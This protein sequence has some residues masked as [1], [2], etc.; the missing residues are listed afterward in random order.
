MR[1]SWWRQ[2]GKLFHLDYFIVGYFQRSNIRNRR[3]I[4]MLYN[5]CVVFSSFFFFVQT[6]RLSLVCWC[7]RCRF[8]IASEFRAKSWK[9]IKYCLL[10]YPND[11]Q[12]FYYFFFFCYVRS[13]LWDLSTLCIVSTDE[14]F[15]FFF[16]LQFFLHICFLWIFIR[17]DSSSAFGI[18]IGVDVAI[19]IVYLSSFWSFSTF[20]IRLY[21]ALDTTIHTFT[22]YLKN[23][24]N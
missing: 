23:I 14:D 22:Y 18:E 8:S 13:V 21:A 7:C 4:V 19:T 16:Y 17:V 2:I 12:H 6:L 24:V 3:L 5:S 15:V 10:C 20:Y 1:R 9:T 11:C